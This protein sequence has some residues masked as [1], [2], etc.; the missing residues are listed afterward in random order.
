MAG[1]GGGGPSAMTTVPA[2][3]GVPPART[4][5]C[6]ALVQAFAWESTALGA[7]AGWDPAVRAAVDLV[8]SCP[9]P[10]TFAAGDDYLLI[11]ND[12]YADVLGAAHPQALGRPAAKVFGELWEQPGVGN[13]IDDVYATGEPYLEAEAQVGT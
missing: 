12:A 1:M 3:G 4:P 11:Y 7:M 9:I 8:L 10:M 6:R 5:G 2:R 13:V